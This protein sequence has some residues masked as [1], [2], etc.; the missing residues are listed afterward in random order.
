MIHQEPVVA[1]ELVYVIV[2]DLVVAEDLG[3]D[4]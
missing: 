4:K 3:V 2:G 1:A